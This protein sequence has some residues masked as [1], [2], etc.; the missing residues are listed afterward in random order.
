MSQARNVLET[1]ID[2]VIA[3]V[4]R[5][6]FDSYAL[7]SVSPAQL[8]DRSGYRR[9]RDEVT[10]ARLADCLTEHPDWA[11][12]WLDY[13][14]DK[15][16]SPGWYIQGRDPDE[17]RVGYYEGESSRA[18][19]RFDDKVRACAEFVR[20]EVDDIAGLNRNPSSR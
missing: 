13:S 11:N 14:E 3:A 16:S 10:V 7:G 12:A 1:D 8:V 4:C 15:R 6:A 19:M 20:L 18:P 2:D 17:S 9:H 5:L